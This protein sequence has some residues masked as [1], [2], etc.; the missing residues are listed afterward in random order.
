[1]TNLDQIGLETSEQMY[2]GGHLQDGSLMDNS[3]HKNSLHSLSLAAATRKKST[4]SHDSQRQSQLLKRN[5]SMNRRK[6]QLILKG[7][8]EKSRR[9]A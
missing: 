8:M 2:M 4:T 6:S 7:Q 5:I 1:M 9:L 3:A